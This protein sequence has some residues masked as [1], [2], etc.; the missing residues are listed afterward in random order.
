MTTEDAIQRKLTIVFI[1]H[2]QPVHYSVAGTSGNITG[3]KCDAGE[4]G[5][6][7]SDTKHGGEV[8][9]DYVSH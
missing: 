6:A 8:L 9:I 7:N 5:L 3:S 2:S 4:S 1:H